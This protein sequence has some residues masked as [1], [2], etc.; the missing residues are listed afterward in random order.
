MLKTDLAAHSHVLC[1][2]T[3][4]ACLYIT[5]ERTLQCTVP[6]CTHY[7]IEWEMPTIELTR[8]PDPYEEKEEPCV[9]NCT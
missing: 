6:S 9:S 2:G 1:P 4:G 8:V 5:E 3:C 7:G